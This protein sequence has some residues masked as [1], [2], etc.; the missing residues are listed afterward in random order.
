MLIA[1]AIEKY[2]REY[3]TNR[4]HDFVYDI[5]PIIK[6]QLVIPNEINEISLAKKILNHGRFSV[7]VLL[8]N[9]TVIK[10]NQNAPSPKLD[11]HAPVLEYGLIKE[12]PYQVQPYAISNKDPEIFRLFDRAIR[13]RRYMLTDTPL[14][15]IGWICDIIPQGPFE[16]LSEYVGKSIYLLDPGSVS[17]MP[18]IMFRKNTNQLPF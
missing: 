17:P 13:H 4:W 1:E 10:L 14:D 6:Q 9:N 2:I 12:F 16:S 11:F 8:E 15:N 3:R 7:A 18:D 5:N